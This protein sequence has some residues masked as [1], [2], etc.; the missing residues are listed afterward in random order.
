M[1]AG[2]GAKFVDNAQQPIDLIEQTLA[3]AAL[4]PDHAIFKSVKPALEDRQ[5]RTQLMRKSRQK[6]IPLPHVVFQW[7]IGSFG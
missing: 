7:I 3:F 1:G 4:R 2:E 6:N 5:G